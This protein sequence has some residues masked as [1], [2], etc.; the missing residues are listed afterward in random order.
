MKFNSTI[1]KVMKEGY[2]EIWPS[3]EYYLRGRKLQISSNERDIELDVVTS[4]LP[5]NHIRSIIK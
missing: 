1:C 5:E 3:F 4:L 2:S